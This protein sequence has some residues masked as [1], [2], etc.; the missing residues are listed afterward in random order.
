MWRDI[1][2][3]IRRCNHFLIT[4]HVNPDGDGIGSAC[5][6]TELLVG[7]G[8]HVRFVCDSAIPRKFDF[9][10]FHGVHES[11]LPDED[12]SEVEV[13]IVLDTHQESRI[14]G[15]ANVLQQSGVV[16]I[17]IDH[18]EINDPISAYLCIDPGVC[19]AGALV[20]DLFH[21]FE[22][23]LNKQA[24]E[25]IYV[26]VFSDTGRFSNSATDH[27]AHK[28]AEDCVAVGVNP[29]EM[30]DRLC[31]VLPISH[32]KMFAQ[33]LQNMEVCMGGQVVL[34]VIYRESYAEGDDDEESLEGA[35]LDY[36]HDFN[37]LIEDVKCA[38]LLR[39]LSSGQVRVS[40]R[41]REGLDVS[42]L[43]QQLGGGGHSR[44]AGAN[45]NGT[46]EQVKKQVL[47]LVE[48]VLLSSEQNAPKFSNEKKL[49]NKKHVEAQRKH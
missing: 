48:K 21:A 5:A 6:L 38:I 43:M 14:G 46:V 12:Y 27:L 41:S 44:A 47:E 24:A 11:Y 17:C 18:H 2:D 10:D 8:K 31:Q 13:V 9:L 36:I 35:D 34:Q 23:A 40:V 16:A 22:V 3:V 29:D 4:T 33:A 49:P 1:I 42:A 26:S 15:V 30:F 25:G 28:I 37:K 45:V 7:M 19:A 39:E 20:Y 32:V